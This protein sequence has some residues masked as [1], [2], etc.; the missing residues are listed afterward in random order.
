MVSVSTNTIT[1]TTRTVTAVFTNG[2]LTSLR[3]ADGAE[4]IAAFDTTGSPLQLLYPGH[5]NVDVLGKLAASFTTHRVNDQTAQFRFHGWNADGVLT[6]GEDPAT[7][8]VLVEPAAYASRPGALACRWLMPGIAADTPVVA[9]FFQG[10]RLRYDDPLLRGRRW[11]WPMFWEAALLI[12]DRP[13]VGFWVH[14]E[15]TQYRYKAVE[16]TDAG[17]AFDTE[18]YGPLDGSLGSGG[19]VFRINV[20]AGGWQAPAARYRDWLWQAYG[21]AAQ[22]AVRKDWLRDLRLAVSWYGGDLDLL[23]ALAEQID[24]SKVLLHFSN[25]RTDA[26]DENY[27]TYEPSPNARAVMAKGQ[28]M[29]FHLSPHANSVDMDPTHPTYAFLRDF[30]YRDVITRGLHGW[31]W[32]PEA[33]AILGVPASNHN[34]LENRH[35]KVM[36]K[37]HP[38][39][40]MWRS[41]LG[42]RILQAAEQVATD[43][44]FIDVTL[45]S[46]NLHNCLVENTTATE[47]MN[48]LIREVAALG[49]GLAVGGEGLNEIT[50]QGLSFAQAHLFCSWHATADGLDRT[51]GCPLN[52][53]LF[54]RLCRTIGYSRLSGANEDEELRLRIHVEHGAIPTITVRDAD[55]IRQ[56]NRGVQQMLDL[57]RA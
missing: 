45:C 53:F 17:V 10:V 5:A 4:Q 19:L 7:G 54:G 36:I 13:G 35:R 39:L 16:F 2:F 30:Q 12:F 50:M 26:Y 3:G 25:W 55:A 23:D 1:V 40:T 32:D 57:A 14:C 44:M 52:E 41:L 18:A 33:G 38:G 42:E 29:G 37:V 15:D 28:A 9:P 49:R 43:T 48:K 56:P 6:I 24:P 8:D 21:L 51:G 11:T 34:L 22:E 46:G 20:C 47:G 31:A 27:P